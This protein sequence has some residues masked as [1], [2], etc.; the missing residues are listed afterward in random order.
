M[1]RNKKSLCLLHS[2]SLS[3]LSS[4]SA[5]NGHWSTVAW[6]VPRKRFYLLLKSMDLILHS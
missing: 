6:K 2:L 4:L 3:F 1:N 5:Q